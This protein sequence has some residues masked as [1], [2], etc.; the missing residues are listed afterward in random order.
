MRSRCCSMIFLCL[1]NGPKFLTSFSNSERGAD[2]VMR[3]LYNTENCPT[4]KLPG[5]EIHAFRYRVV[6]RH[7]CEGSTCW[8]R[9]S[10]LA[11]REYV[12]TRINRETSTL[13]TKHAWCYWLA[14]RNWREKLTRRTWREIPSAL[15]AL[16]R[17]WRWRVRCYSYYDLI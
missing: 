7:R 11:W 13:S 5:S 8:I 17:P 6:N 14:T 3:H 1:G 16:P 9:S 2:V 15:N 4:L 12:A 10:A